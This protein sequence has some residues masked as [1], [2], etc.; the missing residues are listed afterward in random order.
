MTIAYRHLRERF[1]HSAKCGERCTE[2]CGVL[3]FET[4]L[5]EPVLES[6]IAAAKQEEDRFKAL[7]AEAR[8]RQ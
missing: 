6:E 2:D 1:L 3:A 5:S 7:A 4:A 8:G